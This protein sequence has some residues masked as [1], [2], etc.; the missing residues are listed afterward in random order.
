MKWVSDFEEQWFFELIHR[1][2]ALSAGGMEII[3]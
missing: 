1:R 3:R 2:E